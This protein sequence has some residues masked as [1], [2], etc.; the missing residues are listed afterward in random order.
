MR[1]LP[2]QDLFDRSAACY[3]CCMRPL[4]SLLLKKWR[5]RLLA[6]A[7]G[8]VLEIGIGTGINLQHYPAGVTAVTGIDIS[9]PMLARA[10]PD[11][12]ACPIDLHAMDAQQLSFPDQTFDTVVAT[13]VFCSVPDPRQGLAEA[14]RVCRPD[15]KLLFLEHVRPTHPLLAVAADCLTCWTRAGGEYFNRL[16][17]PDLEAAGLVARRVWRGCGG[18]LLAVEATRPPA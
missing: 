16:F 4:E 9:G 5:A 15:G 18:A 14:G 13:L 8:H 3:D 10:T 2:E 6:D 7:H 1:D 12:P 11:L 17:L